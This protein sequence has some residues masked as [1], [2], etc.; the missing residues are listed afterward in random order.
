MK[1]QIIPLEEKPYKVMGFTDDLMVL[2]S[3]EH[4]SIESLLS[5]VEKKGLME[6]LKVINTNS[7]KEITYNEKA[8]GM[9]VRYEDKGKLKKETIMIAESSYR[10]PI[11]TEVANT[12]QL[13]KNIV[14]ESKTQPLLLNILGGII[15]A[16]VTWVARGLALDAEQGEHYVATGR[17]SGIAQL[18]VNAVEAIGPLGVTI[19]GTL[20]FLYFIYLANKR[21]KNPA[22]EVKFS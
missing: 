11:A 18:F 15:T 12:N 20:V 2:S 1:N 16:V 17:R 4:G 3:K 21:Y 14:E 7:I 13:N 22:L 5:A 8:K 10:E 6:S 19:I 9:V